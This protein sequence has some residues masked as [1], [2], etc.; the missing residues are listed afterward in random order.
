MENLKLFDQKQIRSQWDETEGKWYFSVIDVIELLTDS[1]RPR[2]YW[3][4]IKTKLLAE[5]SELSQESGQL[6]FV[7]EHFKV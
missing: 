6:K 4:A 3:S 2:K 7:A 5:G 1:F